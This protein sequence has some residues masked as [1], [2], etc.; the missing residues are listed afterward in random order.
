MFVC[1]LNK[2]VKLHMSSEYPLK[3]QYDLDDW[4]DGDLENDNVEEDNEI[5]NYIRFFVAPKI[6]RLGIRLFLDKQY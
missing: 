3:L 5:T 6:G 2:Q 1:K 4:T